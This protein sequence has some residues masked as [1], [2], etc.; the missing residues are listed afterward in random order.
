[1]GRAGY[2]PHP[3]TDAVGS[4]ANE[5]MTNQAAETT[6]Q[7]WRRPLLVISDAETTTASHA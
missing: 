7:G 2:F 1:M 6:N 4:L 5:E 3:I